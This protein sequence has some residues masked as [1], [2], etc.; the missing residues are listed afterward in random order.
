M[1]NLVVFIGPTGIGKKYWM[2]FIA[3]KFPATLHVVPITTTR[4]LDNERDRFFYS[5][6]SEKDFLKRQAAGDPEVRKFWAT[7]ERQGNLGTLYYGF[8]RGELRKIPEFMCGLIS[9]SPGHLDTLLFEVCKEMDRFAVA[10]VRLL[11]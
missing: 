7:Y 6:M 2:E 8:S 10:V 9:L 5:F 11:Q 1:A 3:N 4:P